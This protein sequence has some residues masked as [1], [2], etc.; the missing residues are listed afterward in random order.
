[1]TDFTHDQDSGGKSAGFLKL[2]GFSGIV[3]A[4]LFFWFNYAVGYFAWNAEAFGPHYW[5]QR[6]GL[7]VHI[8]GGT[9]ALLIGPFQIWMG[10]KHRYMNIHRVTGF[11][12]LGG[13]AV[14]VI[15]AA[16]M[17]KNTVADFGM[18]FAIG[19]GGLA[20]AWVITGGMAYYAIRKRN[21]DQHRE[22][23]IRSYVVT[24]AF[25]TFRLFDDYIPHAGLGMTQ[26]DYLAMLSWT[27]WMVPLM[28]TEAI[29]QGRKI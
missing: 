9:L 23:M 28:I 3:L 21:Y 22:W 29:M 2:L 19:L 14:G 5:P 11:L 6:G 10:M 7:I 13:L 25:A 16:T 1:M 26:V 18:H 20:M 24:F 8:T 17:L 12:Y 27:S 15:G 4:A